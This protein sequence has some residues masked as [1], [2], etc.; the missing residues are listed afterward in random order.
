MHFLRAIGFFTT[1]SLSAGVLISIL[2]QFVKKRPHT[3]YYRQGRSA[4]LLR[5]GGWGPKMSKKYYVVY[6]RSLMAPPKCVANNIGNRREV[7]QINVEGN[8]ILAVD[9]I[10]I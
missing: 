1:V 7:K 6:G 5:E 10:L 2:H 4:I 8:N 3:T 9:V